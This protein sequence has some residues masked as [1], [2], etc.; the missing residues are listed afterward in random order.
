LC[1]DSFYTAN[2]RRADKKIRLINTCLRL[3]SFVNDY[4]RICDSQSDCYKVYR[5]AAF[6]NNF[7]FIKILS[8]SLEPIGTKILSK[9]NLLG[10]NLQAQTQ[11][12]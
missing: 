10:G 12:L 2:I 7:L 4:C 9:N 5:Q 11:D 8:I 6:L 1:F 3:I